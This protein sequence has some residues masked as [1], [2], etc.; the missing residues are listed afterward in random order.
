MKKLLA[1]VVALLVMMAAGAMFFMNSARMESRPPDMAPKTSTHVAPQPLPITDLA[2][3]RP[4]EGRFGE[5]ELTGGGT[6]FAVERKSEARQTVPESG[7]AE[8]KW[9]VTAKQ[10][11]TQSLFLKLSTGPKGAPQPRRIC[12]L[13]RKVQVSGS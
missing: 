5:A 10:A 2:A 8:W 11:G 1:V 7:V 9:S 12:D 13:E 3:P 6:A 4:P